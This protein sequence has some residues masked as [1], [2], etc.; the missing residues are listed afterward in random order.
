MCLLSVALHE[1]EE[2]GG[3]H[4]ETK[5]TRERRRPQINDTEGERGREE[6]LMR[7]RMKRVEDEAKGRSVLKQRGCS[8]KEIRGAAGKLTP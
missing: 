6:G 5:V 4:K 2:V 7:E 3:G 1:Q 8:E